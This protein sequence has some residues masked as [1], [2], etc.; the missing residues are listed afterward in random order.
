MNTETNSPQELD[1]ALQESFDITEQDINPNTLGSSPTDTADKNTAYYWGDDEP[2]S[3]EATFLR[4]AA[5]P[6]VSNMTALA[7]RQL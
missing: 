5:A 6:A 2:E 7:F 4:D 3:E 1:N